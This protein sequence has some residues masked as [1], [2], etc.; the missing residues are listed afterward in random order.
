MWITTQA[1]PASQLGL[2]LVHPLSNKWPSDRPAA[3]QVSIPA[4]QL[5]SKQLGLIED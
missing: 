2:Q 3:A 1:K 5:M 4:L